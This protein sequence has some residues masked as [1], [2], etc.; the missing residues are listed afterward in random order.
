MLV[1]VFI[2]CV[3]AIYGLTNF[4][5]AKEAI[6][7]ILIMWSS[8]SPLVLYTIYS[9]F[10]LSVFIMF[11]LP[12]S[13]TIRKY[14][15]LFSYYWMGIY[16]YLFLTILMSEIILFVCF[17]FGLVSSDFQ[18]QVVLITGW[19][20]FLTVLAT[21]VYGRV[22]AKDI[23]LNSYEV[24][25][26]KKTEISELKIALISDIHFNNINNHDH[27]NKVVNKINSVNPDIVCFSGDIFDGDY[28]AVENP[29]KIQ[30]LLRSINTKY[31]IYACIGNHDAGKTYNE[32]IE[33][34]EKSSVHVLDDNYISVE[35]KF[36]IAGRKDSSPIGNQGKI[37]S[38]LPDLDV[39]Y[40]DLP[41]IVLD[42]Q[43]SNIKEYNSDVDL[44][45]CGHTHKG[46]LFPLNYIT[47][48]IFDVDYGYYKK[49]QSSPHVIV[50][51]GVGTWGPPF[52]IG[53]D[54]EV[55]NIN[56][57]FNKWKA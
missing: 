35:N 19:V 48:A 14:I 7:W 13:F 50:S 51:S 49:D 26:N 5:I 9:I 46:Q 39:Q 4:M 1:V 21:L 30:K 41:V 33:F 54:N 47:N 8:S 16:F 29:E 36:I 25:I 45:L 20:V 28:Y 42:H 18:N 10:A 55:V 37:R 17:Q 43:P 34:L 27:F 2:L 6:T 53:T 40:K 24:K 32:M 56:V 15:A 3:F 44:V 12:A 23:K 38:K 11:F 57:L 52:R 31:G 22:N